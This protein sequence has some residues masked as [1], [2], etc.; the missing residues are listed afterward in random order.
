MVKKKK[1]GPKRAWLSR[2]RHYWN[3]NPKSSHARTNISN[4]VKSGILAA[5]RIF[6]NKSKKRRKKTTSQLA[7]SAGMP[8][9]TY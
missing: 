7:E 3:K 4:A 8:E 5:K 9:Q 2:V 6:V 1:R